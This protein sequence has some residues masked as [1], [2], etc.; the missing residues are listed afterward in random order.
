MSQILCQPSEA[1]LDFVCQETN[2]KT[3]EDSTRST[4]DLCT[5]ESST[6]HFMSV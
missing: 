1:S 4:A 2:S 5:F 3:V 6:N